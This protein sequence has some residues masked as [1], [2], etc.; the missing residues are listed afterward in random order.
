MI[1]HNLRIAWR[2]LLKYKLQ[3]TISILS[4]TV[5]M[6]C[7]AL[8]ALWLRYEES[9]DAWW[10]DH[11]DIYMLQGH[12]GGG[13]AMERGYSDYLPFTPGQQLR[14]TIPGIELFARI[15]NLGD[16]F[17][18]PS[19]S[20]DGVDA[21][22]C[23]I[24]EGVQDMLGIKV[25]EGRKK[26]ILNEDEAALTR[27]TAERLFPDGKALG[28]KVEVS[29]FFE[30]SRFTVVAI[31]E[32]PKK[33]SSFPYSFVTGYSKLYKQD[34]FHCTTYLAKIRPENL[35]AVSKALEK[36]A[37]HF[38][39]GEA[40][41]ADGGVR[42][43]MTPTIK[44]YSFRLMT[45]DEMRKN[46]K[47]VY[48]VV[49]QNHLQLF[50]VLGVIVICCALF[51]YFTTLITRIRIRQREL[52]LRYVNGAT[53][54]NLITLVSTELLLILLFSTLLSVCI[55]SLTIEEFKSIC[56]IDQ[57]NSFFIGWFLVYAMSAA[58]V[59]IVITA[60]IIY[61]SNRRQLHQALDKHRQPVGQSRIFTAHSVLL[62]LQIAVSLGAVFCSSVMMHQIN[63]LLH[64]PDMGFSKHNRG[65][66]NLSRKSDES[67]GQEDAMK[68][69]AELKQWPELEEYL[70]D[71][72]YPIPNGYQS[73]LY[74]RVGRDEEP[75]QFI[76]AEADE[77]YFKFMEIQMVDGE[78]IK[79]NDDPHLV[80]ISESAARALGEQGKV[81]GQFDANYDYSNTI[82]S[83]T[84]KG[85]CKDLSYTSPLTPTQ[86]MMFTHRDPTKTYKLW[87]DSPIHWKEGTDIETLKKKIEGLGDKLYPG[88]EVGAY[89]D[90]AE[91]KYDEYLQ[92]EH[93][94]SRLLMLVTS[95]CVF[96][97]IF[98]IFSMVSLACER[99][100]KE[101]AIR[102]VHG[103]KS[104]TIVQ[105]FLREYIYMLLAAAIIAFPIGYYLM[106]QWLMQYAKQAPVYWWIYPAILLAMALLI[107][108]T[109][110]WQI[111]KAAG[112]N[113]ADVMKSD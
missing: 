29:A 50:V 41:S 63:F 25:I 102:K 5:G 110:Y 64:S 71:Y 66:I 60:T 82:T 52:A 93:T 100:R 57:P 68:L 86:P 56:C 38:G 106:H 13:Y 76:Y 74:A 45:L 7:F 73:T 28:Q 113:P 33:P 62:A 79:A 43:T 4:L 98:G 17:I 81:G 91:E 15:T 39:G 104:R 87:I 21:R 90:V 101:I 27:S 111:R 6:I 16:A 30:T 103:A 26:L 1:L 67:K 18:H 48:K 72:S 3:T 83:Y 65:T 92:S 112:E 88:E 97:A 22:Y 69:D 47:I 42:V 94:L 108:L 109:I 51:N 32:D 96:I 58:M 19:T 53:M 23:M 14:E 20:E 59:S 80:C 11:D 75:H 34:A 85:I 36:V 44:D 84:V 95:V 12:D 78:F 99:R 10:P 70:V 46:T 107:A 24:D 49:E 2:N 105:M 61:Y 9:Y 37:I 55:V 31:I 40:Q 77:H 89:I 54:W 35:D 8:S